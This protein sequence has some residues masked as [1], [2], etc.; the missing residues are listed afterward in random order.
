MNEL[1]RWQ[2]VVMARITSG[3]QQR[4]QPFGYTPPDITTVTVQN[5]RIGAGT[6]TSLYKS[7]QTFMQQ[8]VAQLAN[9]NFFRTTATDDLVRLLLGQTADDAVSDLGDADPDCA[10][11][12]NLLQMYIN[13]Y[14]VSVMVF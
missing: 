3:L 14:Y 7:F 9:N 10:N 1:Q 11:R 6:G 5:S 8:K 13:L 4:G 12:D 2:A